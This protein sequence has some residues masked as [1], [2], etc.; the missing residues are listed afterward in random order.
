MTGLF[1]IILK[2]ITPEK[3]IGLYTLSI[4]ESTYL[5]EKI[6]TIGVFLTLIGTFIGGVWANESWGRYWGWD[7]KET[8]SLIIVLIY[9]VVL[10]FK[11]IPQMKSALIFNIGSIISF[12]SV[13][14]TFIGVNYY[15]TKGL[16]SYASDDPPVFP[17][18]AWI[19]IVALLTFIIAAII[20]SHYAARLEQGRS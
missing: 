12:G 2:I 6:M 4:Q 15:F 11:Y 3:K 17:V 19:S 20:K 5:N 1:N 16:H 13:L 9:S 8:W 10:H 18:W 14:M 7:P